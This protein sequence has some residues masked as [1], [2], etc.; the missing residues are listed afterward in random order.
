MHYIWGFPRDVVH[1]PRSP[2]SL[3]FSI[4]PIWFSRERAPARKRTCEGCTRALLTPRCER[5]FFCISVFLLYAPS[6]VLERGCVFAPSLYFFSYY[7]PSL[8]LER[9]CV[10]APSFS[11]FSYNTPSLVLERRRVLTPSVSFFSFLH[12]F[13][14]P[15]AKACFTPSLSF[16]IQLFTK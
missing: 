6:L 3:P 8:V 9:G 12:A 4:A 5:A 11:F 16:I 1:K 15:R 10:L 14:R 2:Y 13:A 7:A